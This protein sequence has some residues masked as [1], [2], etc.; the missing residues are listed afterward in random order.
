MARQ[1]NNANTESKYYTLS[2]GDKCST[3][4]LHALAEHDALFAA[5]LERC[6]Y[7]ASVFDAGC[8]T[9]VLLS[10]PRCN[11]RRGF[12]LSQAAPYC[13]IL[14]LRQFSFFRTLCVR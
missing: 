7:S 11:L 3:C 14:T 1:K 4:G 2:D 10:T 12:L 13:P 8:I 9:F 5:F 6:V